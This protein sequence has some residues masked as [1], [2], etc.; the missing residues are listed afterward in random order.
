VF[1]EV[2]A[3]IDGERLVGEMVEGDLALAAATDVLA[4][5]KVALPMVRGLIRRIDAR[6][7]P[8]RILAVIPERNFGEAMD[9]TAA[10]L[11]SHTELCA[12]DHPHPSELSV[13]A[14]RSARVFVRAVSDGVPGRLL[15]LLSGGASSLLCGPAKGLAW[16][17]KRDAVAA[18]A[19][20]GATIRELNVVRKH[21]SSIKGGR[22][23]LDTSRPIAVRALS[24]VIGDDPATIGSGPFSPDPS[25]FADAI[26][27]VDR[28]GA[29]LPAAARAH[30]ERG[31]RGEI[32]DTPKPGTAEL[33][34]VDYRV[35]AGPA[36]V[37]EEA[38]AAIGRQVC[39]D[40]TL[41]LA[42]EETVEVH[43]A[44]IA[45]RARREL[46]AAPDAPGHLPRI[47]VGNGEPRVVLPATAGRGGRAP[48][49][50]LLVAR[51]L[52]ELPAPLRSRVAF[53]AA[54]TDDRDGNTD[55]SGAIV[56]GTTWERARARGLDPEAALRAYD[57]LPVLAAVGDT[58]RGPGTSNLLDLHLLHLP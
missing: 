2:A 11:P 25:T 47:L 30:L 1:R 3:R 56:D 14:A 42:V 5:G 24:D 9:E 27:V 33:A 40:G 28:L 43:A 38:R 26:A 22:L 17:D 13:E 8:R 21:L 10:T 15:V 32:P 46:G 4:A 20:A 54:G 48:H 49:L 52:A 50:A 55:V 36:R 44:A 29:P 6:A 16:Q 12:A 34:H 31:A 53:L 35:L 23:A 58:L 45:E 18:V 39:A 19:R 7:W 41:A 37:V 57:S 51:E